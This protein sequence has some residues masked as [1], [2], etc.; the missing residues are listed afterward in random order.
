MLIIKRNSITHI[1]KIYILVG[2]VIYLIYCY[3]I[4]LAGTKNSHFTVKL[5]KKDKNS[6]KV[7]K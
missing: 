7:V 4:L 5:Q 2:V 6:F 1:M 3:L